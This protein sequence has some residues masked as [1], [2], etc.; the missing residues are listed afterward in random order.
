MSENKQPLEQRTQFDSGK[1]THNNLI[2]PIDRAYWLHKIW[3]TEKL[4][5]HADLEEVRILHWYKFNGDRKPEYDRNIEYGINNSICGPCR[6]TVDRSEEKTADALIISNEPLLNWL[7]TKSYK[8]MKFYAKEGFVEP[9]PSIAKRNTS[10]F[11]VFQ[12]KESASK[13]TFITEEIDGA[14]NFTSSYR[15][16]A[17]ITRYFGDI[18][19]QIENYNPAEIYERVMK[20]KQPYGIPLKRYDQVF[21]SVW[22]VSNCNHSKGA[23][24]RL[25]YGKSLIAAGLKLY[26]EG[27]CFNHTTIRVKGENIKTYK[28]TLPAV[29]PKVKM[30]FYLAFEK[31]YHCNDFITDKFWHNALRENLV[32]IVYG[33]HVDDVR[34]IAP[35][36]S[37]IHAEWFESPTAL[38]EYIDYL[39]SNDTAYFQYHE[40]RTLYPDDHNPRPYRLQNM[41]VNDRALCELCR[42]VR[43]KRRLRIRQHYE[44]VRDI[45]FVHAHNF[46]VY[47]LLFR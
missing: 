33:P 45:I 11:W 40:W 17:D 29:F 32:P 9:F 12:M 44:S 47:I 21:N 19:N 18:E 34:K 24:G 23:I 8:G 38:V 3:K 25:E 14:F 15:Q 37:L 41:G 2:K 36:N 35:P 20:S 31:E 1:K 26:A 46:N 30:K 42:T 4:K 27:E 43:N 16:D 7:K 28:N 6:V 22:M 10:Q 13:A 39:D 5:S